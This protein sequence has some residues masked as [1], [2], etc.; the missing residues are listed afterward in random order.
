M[1]S[2]ETMAAFF[3]TALLL[4]VAPG[5]DNIF[6]LT[7]S[8]L[9]GARAGIAVTIGLVSGL[10]VHTT[11]VALGVAAL[12]QSLPA[13]FTAL[14]ILGA[15]YLLHLARLCFLAGTTKAD[16]LRKGDFPGYAAL[17]RR[18]VVM[19]VTNPKVTLFF[20]AFL[21]RFCDAGRGNVFWQTIML[22]GLFICATILVFFSVAGLGGRLAAWFARSQRGQ[23][24]AH[25]L[26]GLIFIALALSLLFAEVGG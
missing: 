10:C 15:A 23:A 6:V 5:P 19:N 9:Y 4:G 3:A 7:Q 25:R 12:L 22:G 16:L 14:K 1:L 24:L 11:A 18:G 17:Y 8:T 13:A 20:L 21:P 2:P 26:T